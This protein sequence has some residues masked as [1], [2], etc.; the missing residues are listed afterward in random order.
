MIHSGG[1]VYVSGG[2]HYHGKSL[3]R[4]LEQIVTDVLYHE[5]P[6]QDLVSHV[7]NH[8]NN[9]CVLVNDNGAPHMVKIVHEYMTGG[10]LCT[11]I[12]HCTVQI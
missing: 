8:S 4:I 11:L 9:N 7:H 6:E 10:I 3:L 2:V 5:I 1:L 12:G